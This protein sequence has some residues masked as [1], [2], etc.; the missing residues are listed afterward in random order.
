MGNNL[1]AILI[2]QQEFM[3]QLTDERVEEYREFLSPNVRHRDPFMDAKGVDAVLAAM[4]KL[5]KDL[6][7]LQFKNKAYALQGRQAFL[8]WQMIFRVKKNPKRLWEV[9]GVSKIVFDDA[10]KIEDQIDYWDASP[11]LESFP[12]LGKVV[13]LVKKIIAG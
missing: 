11:F 8:H 3:E 1:D 12:I 13:T 2:R 7:D 5:F 4:H 6:D 10:D 9:D